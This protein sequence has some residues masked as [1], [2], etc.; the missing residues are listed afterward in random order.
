MK[1]TEVPRL[2]YTVQEALQA[3]PIGRSKLFELIASG[4][5]RTITIGSRRLIPADSLATLAE[6]GAA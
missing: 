1:R 6:E 4:E 2:A 3:V 5:L